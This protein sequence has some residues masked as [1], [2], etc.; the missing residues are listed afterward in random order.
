MPGDVSRFGWHH[1][2]VPFLMSLVVLPLEIAAQDVR[3]MELPQATGRLEGTQFSRIVGV[4]ELNDGRVLVS[5]QLERSLYIVD[6]ELG[7][8]HEIGS[9][10]DGPGEYQAPGYLYGLGGDTTVMVDSQV[11]RMILLVGDSIVRTLNT[12]PGTLNQLGGRPW[13]VDREGRVLGASGY[14]YSPGVLPLSRVEADSLRLLLSTGSVF[15]GMGTRFETIAEVGGQGRQGAWVTFQGRR[16]YVTSPLA[17]EGQGWLF[18]DGW[19][20]VAYPEPYRVDWLRPDGS[21]IRGRSNS[22][23]PARVT[24]QDKCLA[25]RRNHD[26]ADCRETLA[27]RVAWPRYLPTFVMAREW[28]TPGGIALLPAPGGTLL[29]RRTATAAA[30]GTRYD[31]VARGGPLIAVLSLPEGSAIVGLG[32]SC[33]YVVTADTM[34]LLTLSRHPWL[35]GP[36]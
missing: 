24:D 31:I 7:G 2:L 19:V 30:P 5:D 17:S 20:A 33:L 28:I 25:E 13:G 23:T 3:E 26:G 12:P 18:H 21:W 9:I 36:Q 22:V 8:V 11:F 16:R 1:A 15:S 4:S 27:S 35:I 10:G 32:E 14:A 6:F 29:V 34:G